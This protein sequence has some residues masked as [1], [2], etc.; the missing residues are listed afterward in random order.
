MFATLTK[1]LKNTMTRKMAL[2]AASAVGLAGLAPTTAQAHERHHNSFG[3]DILIGDHG[4]WVP[5]VC[6]ERTTRVW[7]EPAYRTVCDTVYEQP[8]YRTVCDRV[9]VEPVYRTTCERVL[10][11]D[12]FETREV[13]VYDC[14]RPHLERRRVLVRAAHYENVERRVLVSDGHWNNVERQVVVRE[15]GYRKIERQELVTPGHFEQRTERVEVSPGHWEGG[16]ASTGFD[17]RI[18]N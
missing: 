16:Y 17:L 11:P 12:C 15:G 2:I 6:E 8:V 13:T 18:R 5:P 1:T 14:G 4:R 9:W 10:V 3:L 7:V